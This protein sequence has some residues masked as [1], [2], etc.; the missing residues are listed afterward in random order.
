MR[1][2]RRR[3]PAEGSQN[4]PHLQGHEGPSPQRLLRPAQ[5]RGRR[6]GRRTGRLRFHRT[7][8]R[9][10]SRWQSAIGPCG[11]LCGSAPSPAPA[12]PP[13]AEARRSHKKSRDQ[14]WTPRAPPVSA[15]PVSARRVSRWRAAAGRCDS[16][17]G[18][19]RHRLRR[20]VRTCRQGG[21]CAHLG[22]R[23]GPR[24]RRPRCRG[25][26]RE[27][28]SGSRPSPR[29]INSPSTSLLGE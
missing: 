17:T 10:R 23:S 26:Q 6:S 2:V 14:E 28:K 21:C 8:A 5:H 22:A 12:P 29:S 11:Q 9:S 13:V 20:R 25:R 19:R 1:I 7:P 16:R 15:P 27:A 4:A 24:R 3:R 18:R